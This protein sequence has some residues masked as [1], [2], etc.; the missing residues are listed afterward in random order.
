[1]EDYPDGTRYEGMMQQR[2]RHGYGKLIFPDKAYYE[3]N[4]ELDQMHGQGTL[5]YPTTQPAYSGTWQHSHFQG[6]GTIYN[7]H[8]APLSHSFHFHD[9]NQIGQF[10]VKYEGIIL[11]R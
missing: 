8:P 5:Y 7:Q 9:F 11:I 10:W 4:F 1:M 6:R 3:G 2:H